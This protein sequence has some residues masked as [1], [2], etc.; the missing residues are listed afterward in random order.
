MSR[1]GLLAVLAAIL[2]PAVACIDLSVNPNEITSIELAPSQNPSIIFGDS[3]RDTSGKAYA[4]VAHVFDAAGEEVTT[5]EPTFI[6]TD[7]LV[8]IVT[9]DGATYVVAKAV[10]GTARLIASIGTLQSVTRQ[11]DVV[12]PPDTMLRPGVARDTIVFHDPAT[13]A[14]TTDDLALRVVQQNG[15]GVKSLLVRYS[16][17]HEQVTIP[18]TSDTTQQFSLVDAQ[19]RGSSVDTTDASGNAARRLRY[20]VPAGAGKLDSVIV[21]ASVRGLGGVAVKGSPVQLVVVLRPPQ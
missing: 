11:L 8:N 1:R 16:V 21:T 17:E 5:A 7:T 14:D 3:L 10:A 20:R 9:G 4:L 6:A 15:T 18:V 2:V 13:T 19:G 12:P